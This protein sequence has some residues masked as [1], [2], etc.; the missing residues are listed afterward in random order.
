MF[1]CLT[2]I[3]FFISA[4]ADFGSTV[5]T[6]VMQPG[7]TEVCVDIIIENDRVEEGDEEFCVQLS[8]DN[9]DID[10]GSEP[11]H[12]CITLMDP[13]EKGLWVYYVVMYD[14]IQNCIS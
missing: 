12:I 6:R 8:S 1:E 13:L 10:F 5:F 9:N 4:D 7:E 2:E 3:A 11:C 14:V